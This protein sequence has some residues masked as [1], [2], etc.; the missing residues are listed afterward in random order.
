MNI[1]YQGNHQGNIYRH[2]YHVEFGGEGVGEDQVGPTI[3]ITEGARHT[4]Q[5]VGRFDGAT[6]EWHGTNVHIDNGDTYVPVNDMEGYPCEFVDS[7]MQVIR[8]IVHHLR[9]VIKNVGEHTSLDIVVISRI[10]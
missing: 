2:H 10:A 1:E 8:G 5:V 3:S 6:I 4:V 9:P 7:G